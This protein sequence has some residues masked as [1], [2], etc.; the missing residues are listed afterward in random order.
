MQLYCI[1]LKNLKWKERRRNLMLG[2]IRT[3]YEQPPIASRNFDWMAWENGREESALIGHGSTE[4]EAINDLLI[5]L[6]IVRE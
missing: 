4:L 3:S 6:G 5:N 1:V 2:K